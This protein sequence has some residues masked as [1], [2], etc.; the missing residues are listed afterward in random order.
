MRPSNL[1]RTRKRKRPADSQDRR[2]Q[3]VMEETDTTMTLGS[4]ASISDSR[5]K[6]TE[7][8]ESSM[9]TMLKMIK[10]N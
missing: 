9:M 2:R 5:D 4:Q 7:S 3:C 6:P 8:V 10:K 1:P